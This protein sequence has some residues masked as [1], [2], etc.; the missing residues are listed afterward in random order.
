MLVHMFTTWHVCR[1]I[2]CDGE[3]GEPTLRCDG[4][5]MTSYFTAHEP[6][7][8]TSDSI[9]VVAVRDILQPLRLPTASTDWVPGIRIL[10]GKKKT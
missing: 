8:I 7:G 5:G 4:Q 6:A 3:A 10:I 9:I 2:N 1:L